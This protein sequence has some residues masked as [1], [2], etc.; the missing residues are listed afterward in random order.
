[1]SGRSPLALAALA[2]AAVKGL[3]PV[4]A[5][6]H[7]THDRD[8]DT[9]LVEDR[10]ARRWL[11]R[12]P[13][14]TAAGVRIEKE[15][16]LLDGLV[17]ALPFAV[18]EVAG[19]AS[20]PEGG[21]VMVQRTLAGVPL[22]TRA[23]TPGR[24]LAAALGRAL[25]TIHDLPQ[26]LVEEAGMPVYAAEEYRLRRLA[27]VDR[28]AATGHVPAALLTRWEKALEEVGAWRF[29]PCVV[30]G[31]LA[32]ENVLIEHEAVVG[33]LEWAQTLVADP[34]DDLAWLASTV[35]GEA[36]DTV[37]E[38]YTQARRSPPDGDLIRRARLVSE[39]AIARWL[40]HGVTTDDESVIKDAVGMLADLEA[41]VAHTEW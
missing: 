29:V 38:A 22:P 15:S 41:D 35:D 23:L 19:M 28:A 30:H 39:L 16:R 32:G 17:T 27:E 7:P 18:P 31:D 37:L 20:L 25:A 10:L 33:V 4:A 14:T 12:A 1:V 24:G 36:L 26:H 13:R 2:C 40:L 11:V 3:E 8:I 9:A 6:E 34:A 21:R 5:H